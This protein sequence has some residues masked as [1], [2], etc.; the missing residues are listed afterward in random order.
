LPLLLPS[1]RLGAAL[2]G[3]AAG[4][5]AVAYG[6]VPALLAAGVVHG[7]GVPFLARRLPAA[8]DRARGWRR[9]L[10]ALLALATVANGAR[11]TAFMADSRFTPGAP[12]PFLSDG[13]DHACVTAYIRAAELAPQ[14]ENLYDP[15]YYQ[16]SDDRP[17]PTQVAGMGALIE[18][19]YEYPPAFVVLPTTG[20]AITHD[21]ALL[22]AGWFAA[23]ALVILALLL[24]VARWIGG[25]L[26]LRVGLLLPLMWLGVPTMLNFQY[27]QVH[28]LVLAAS[29][30]AMVA[31]AAR[32]DVV[33]GA[34]LGGAVM[35]KVFPGL[36]LVVLL[37]QRR[38]CSGAGVRSRGPCSRC[39]PSPA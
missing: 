33:G 1:L 24:L 8:L 37:V 9:W 5:A 23:Q 38:W 31:F 29:V 25:P 34:L 30:A 21:Y 20:L 7:V 13:L 11:T 16:T 18:D 27:G 3:M 2:V 36:L 35:T 28:L 19:P 39:S 10:W 22:R 14:V 32:R 4:L 6:P 26:G 12:L 17:L 15:S